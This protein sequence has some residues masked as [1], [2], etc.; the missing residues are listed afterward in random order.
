[1]NKEDIPPI[2]SDIYIILSCYNEEETLEEVP[3]ME[4]VEPNE[5]V[6]PKIEFE[7]SDMPETEEEFVNQ[8]ENIT[9]ALELSVVILMSYKQN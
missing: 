5:V 9:K 6:I 8:A 1:M 3:N 2:T 7:E 4:V